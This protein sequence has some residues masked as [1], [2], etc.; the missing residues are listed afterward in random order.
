MRWMKLVSIIALLRGAYASVLFLLAG[1]MAFGI[2]TPFYGDVT[3]RNFVQ[4]APVYMILVWGGYAFAYL[5]AGVL[6]VSGRL[7]L[8]LGLYAIAMA[9]DLSIWSLSATWLNYGQIWNG[10][11][12]PVDLF[13]N[14]LDMSILTAML[15]LWQPWKPQPQTGS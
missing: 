13:F 12:A 9:V 2:E 10:A 15:L 8:G 6:F 1:L 3:L 4:V 5:A 14:L 7:A 11:G